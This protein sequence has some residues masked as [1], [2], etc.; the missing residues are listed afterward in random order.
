MELTCLLYTS[1]SRAEEA[2]EE[3]VLTFQAL[4]EKK[5]QIERRLLQFQREINGEAHLPSPKAAKVYTYLESL[6]EEQKDA[7][8]QILGYDKTVLLERL[9][10]ADNQTWSQMEEH[11]EKRLDIVKQQLDA[12][13][14]QSTSEHVKETENIPD[15]I[16]YET[17]NMKKPGL[18][19][20]KDVYKRQGKGFRRQIQQYGGGV[21]ASGNGKL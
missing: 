20:W 17:E 6:S 13:I 21:S 5:R 18:E 1:S 2:R 12:E 3:F 19:Q 4:S 10:Q 9:K 11:I 7:M 8:A 16:G 14:F 15:E